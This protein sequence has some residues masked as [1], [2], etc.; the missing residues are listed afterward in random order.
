[1]HDLLTYIKK[2][3]DTILSIENMSMRWVYLLTTIRV[4][5]SVLKNWFFWSGNRWYWT[6][7]SRLWVCFFVCLLVCVFIKKRVVG[8]HNDTTTEQASVRE[9]QKSAH[10]INTSILNRFSETKSHPPPALLPCGETPAPELETY[11]IH[12]HM[13]TDPLRINTLLVFRDT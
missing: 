5:G 11:Q 12:T 3:V 2:K 6:F 10:T 7:D 9:G 13:Q 1:M 4:N 8:Q